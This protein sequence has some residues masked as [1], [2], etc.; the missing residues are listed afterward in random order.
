MYYYLTTYSFD[1]SRLVQGPFGDFNA[2]WEA[3]LKDAKNEYRIDVEENGFT[4]E[5]RKD[6]DAGVINLV[7]LVDDTDDNTTTWSAIEIPDYGPAKVYNVVGATMDCK[8][9]AIC[10]VLHGVSLSLR[11]AQNV[12]RKVYKSALLERGLEDNGTSN[13]DGDAIPGGYYTDREAGIYD[14]AEFANDQ[15]LEVDSFAVVEAVLPADG[16]SQL[17]NVIGCNV[18]VV[19]RKLAKNSL[20]RV[21]EKKEE[22]IFEAT[23]YGITLNSDDNFVLAVTEDR[24]LDGKAGTHFG[25]C[26]EYVYGKEVFL[27]LREAVSRREETVHNEHK[28]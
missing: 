22:E 5:L 9:G 4:S 25:R 20:G 24:I 2:C 8:N 10:P 21:Y 7:N 15:L 27:T 14:Y 3:M 12:M 18:Y 19:G 13:E 26:A 17:P 1:S 16:M 11:D 28:I 6:R 23:V